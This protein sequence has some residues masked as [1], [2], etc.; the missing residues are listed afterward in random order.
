MTQQ[1]LF[2]IDSLEKLKLISDPLRTKI[3]MNLIKKEYTGQQ[4]AEL[5]QIPKTKIYF[6]LKELEK[7]GIIEIVKEEEKNGIMQKFYR[8]IARRFIPSDDLLPSHELIETS[9]QVFLETVLTTRNEIEQAPPE[10]FQLSASNQEIRKNIAS[11]YHFHATEAEFN[12]FLMEFK[13]L[14]KKHF[15]ESE[16]TPGSDAKPYMMT[17]IAFQRQDSSPSVFGKEEE[18]S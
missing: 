3:L 18:G 2:I 12:S 7:H 5:L 13:E 11:T 15:K 1:D 8:S 10:T 6:H 9:R 4:L 17:L 16:Q 14:Y